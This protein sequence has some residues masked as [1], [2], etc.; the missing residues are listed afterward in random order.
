MRVR[1]RDVVR[2]GITDSSTLEFLVLVVASFPVEKGGI[3]LITKDIIDNIDTTTRSRVTNI[4]EMTIDTRFEVF[5]F[6]SKA[7]MAVGRAQETVRIGPRNEI[8]LVVADKGVAVP[9]VSEGE[10]ATKDE[11]EEEQDDGD[12]EAKERLFDE[13][14]GEDGN[15]VNE[16]TREEL[17]EHRGHNLFVVGLLGVDVQDVVLVD[18]VHDKE[19]DDGSRCDEWNNDGKDE[20]D[21]DGQEEMRE[22]STVDHVADDATGKFDL[23]IRDGVPTSPLVGE[24]WK[25]AVELHNTT[26]ERLL[27]QPVDEEG[28]LKGKVD[29]RQRDERVI[30]ENLHERVDRSDKQTREDK[31]VQD[32][33]DV[34]VSHH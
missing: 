20:Q 10:E 7:G 28:T 24:V 27:D 33:K 21:G 34:I 30:L 1:R 13:E 19:E 6:L 15:L 5:L 18:D 29:P 16:E 26:D 23:A 8:R 11:R 31:H 9:F 12:D 2:V 22:T 3:I 14:E 32:D 4:F 25:D 17:V